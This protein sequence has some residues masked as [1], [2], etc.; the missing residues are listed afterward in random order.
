MLEKPNMKN[1]DV[2]KKEREYK[3]HHVG[4]KILHNE[5]E[6][7]EILISS[8]ESLCDITNR[9]RDDLLTQ[10]IIEQLESLY[11]EPEN[12]LYYMKNNIELLEQLK[13]GINQFYGFKF[14]KKNSAY[15][16]ILKS[17][18]NQKNE[19]SENE[20]EYLGHPIKFG[21]LKIDFKMPE[22]MVSSIGIVLKI[23]GRTREDL[24]STFII[25][26]L[27]L[28]YQIPEIILNLLK[29]NKEFFECLR[30]GINHYYGTEV[31]KKKELK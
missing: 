5:I 21:K 31:F 18:Y 14:H 24:F 22:I 8:I 4:Y 3:N 13:L 20:K 11:Q 25:N 9:T 19:S 29:D 15:H 10:F 6:I 2:I 17:C 26:V 30:V 27:S 12:I 28:I 1:L 23:T 16:R 7:P